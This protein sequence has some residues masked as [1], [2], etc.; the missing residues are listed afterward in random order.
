MLRL[1]QE[2][3]RQKDRRMSGQQYCLRWNNYQ[4]NMTSVFHQLLQ[5][6]AFVDVTLA[7]NDLSLKAHKVVLSACSSYFQ[8][9]LLENPCKH[10]TIIMPQDVCYADLKFIIE[11]V[12]KGEID[13]SQAEL[14]VSRQVKLRDP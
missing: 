9:L 10:P 11:F 7:C 2:N 8:K 13:V 14:Q 1:F 6:E 4:S 5:N 3:P 12:Y